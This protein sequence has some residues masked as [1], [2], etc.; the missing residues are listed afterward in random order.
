MH[1]NIP[2]TKKIMHI[3]PVLPVYAIILS[4]SACVTKYY[5]FDHNGFTLI[6]V[7]FSS[8][9][10]FC[11]LMVVIN[12]SMSMF[13]SPGYVPKDYKGGVVN[14][15]ENN[16]NV[17]DKHLYCKKCRESRPPRAHHCKVCRRC[18]MKMDHH[19][20]WIANCVGYWNQKNF[21][22]FLLFATIGDFIGFCILLYKLF[23]LE[24]DAISYKDKKI[25]SV[26]ELVYIFMTP[27][28]ILICAI[29]ALSMTIS[30]GLLFWTQTKMIL[31]NQTTIESLIYP[32]PTESPYYYKEK[33]HNF[34]IVMGNSCCQWLN[35][36][37]KRNEFNNG[38]SFSLPGRDNA[39]EKATYINLQDVEVSGS[40]NN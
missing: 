27:I 17:S 6:K 2:V 14:Q 22:L 35:P 5:T 3:M 19:C 12:H 29:I 4:V 1:A 8:M 36:A 20:P 40:L 15:L 26:G 37:F 30:I 9:F 21:Y 23:D 38:D 33:M 13:I 10:Y 16:P 31:C 7:L 25:N 11:S 28:V 18:V 32:D 39:D 24:N 34:R